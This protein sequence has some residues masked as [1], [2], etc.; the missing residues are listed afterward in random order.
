MQNA[1]EFD[2]DLAD[3]IDETVSVLQLATGLSDGKP[4]W[5]YV[6]MF[7]TRYKEYY[8]KVT[9]GQPVDLTEYGEV[10]VKG[11]GEEPPE[12]I[13]RQM[14]DE[15]GF[16]DGFEAAILGVMNQGQGE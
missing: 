2:M 8:T 11:W 16:D 12:E 1:P 15:Y 14:V 3:D 5:A 13:R 7:P 4:F 10:L 6:A 9:E